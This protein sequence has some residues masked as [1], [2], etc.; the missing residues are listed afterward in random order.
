MTRNSTNRSGRKSQD[1]IHGD[2]ISSII[3]SLE[4]E[5]DTLLAQ[6]AGREDKLAFALDKLSNESAVR[7]ELETRVELLQ[8]QTASAETIRQE[9]A[10]AVTERKRI[11]RV[12]EET[13]ER[14]HAVTAERNALVGEAAA[15][16]GSRRRIHA[17][18]AEMRQLR[19]KILDI[20]RLADKLS[21]VQQERDALEEKVRDLIRT[22]GESQGLSNTMKLN[23]DATRQVVRDMYCQQ[24]TSDAEIQLLRKQIEDAEAKLD[25][26]QKELASQTAGNR[27]LELKLRMSTEEHETACSERDTALEMYQDLRDGAMR[28]IEK[29]RG[30]NYEND[31]REPAFDRMLV[32]K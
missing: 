25:Q 27:Q 11:F 19:A 28:V 6:R 4:G 2:G 29:T 14:L 8:A 21:K 1:Q 32:A 20:N 23:L 26:T 13:N 22:L 15:A 30:T 12:I 9:A 3:S 5:V 16:N 24:E 17:V 7:T 18:K 31:S 10:V